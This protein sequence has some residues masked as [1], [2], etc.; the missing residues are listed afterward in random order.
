MATETTT[1]ATGGSGG[2]FDWNEFAA[3]GFSA[4]QWLPG[5][6]GSAK[7][8]NQAGQYNANPY[9]GNPPVTTTPD[10][11]K[12][13]MYIGIGVAVLLLIIGLAF[14]LSHNKSDGDGEK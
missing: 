3:N 14:A 4:L 13:W 6:I 7:G 12:M 1:T 5:I 9:G 8:G 2:K 11:K 10:N